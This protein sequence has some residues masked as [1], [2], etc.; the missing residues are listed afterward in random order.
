M[1]SDVA[2]RT[3][4]ILI[5]IKRTEE[6]GISY[7]SSF[8]KMAWGY[9]NLRNLMKKIGMMISNKGQTNVKVVW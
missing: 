4:K 6:L 2:A 8:L 3:I 7:F 1:L 9:P 5:Q